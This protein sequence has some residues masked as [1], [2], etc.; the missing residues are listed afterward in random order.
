[1]NDDDRTVA[2]NALLDAY[3]NGPIEP[4][5]AEH[6]EMTIDDAYAVQMEQVSRWMAAGRLIKGLKVGL[7]SAPMRA[8]LNVDQPDF[9]HLF[10]DMFLPAGH[11]VPAGRF[12]Q[13]R[14]EPEI[15]FVLGRRLSGPGVTFAEAM[16]AIDFALPSLEVI[17]SRI[18][19]WRI[20]ITDTIADNASSGGVV[21]GGRAA[22]VGDVD[23]SAVACEL[24]RN[25][26]VVG[27]GT[28]AAVL[29]HPV[30]ALA[31]LANTLGPLGVTLEHGQVVLPGSMTAAVAVGH[32]DIVSADFGALGSVTIG[33]E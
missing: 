28:G 3:G 8:Q 31:W 15:A 23:L 27:S 7:T 21:L 24:R 26:E 18:S 4:P 9:G 22:R 10:E 25:G 32:G 6:P 20:T 17:D 16:A 12:L 33:F 29:G 5:S 30:Q 2:A 13:P 19:N 14:V 1:M 11:T